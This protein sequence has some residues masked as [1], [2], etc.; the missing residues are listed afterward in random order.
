MLHEGGVLRVQSDIRIGTRTDKKQTAQDKID[1]VKEKM[2][3][4]F[5]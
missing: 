4:G 2:K 5:N 3:K 1:V